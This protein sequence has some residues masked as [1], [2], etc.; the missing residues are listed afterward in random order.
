MLHLE[1]SLKKKKKKKK[2]KK[3]QHKSPY[4]INTYLQQGKHIQLW[5]AAVRSSAIC[6]TGRRPARPS[7]GTK[8]YRGSWMGEGSNVCSRGW[9]QESL[10]CIVLSG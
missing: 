10:H 3:T 5:Q 2:K 7:G 1:Y 8:R 9:E 4:T 6:G